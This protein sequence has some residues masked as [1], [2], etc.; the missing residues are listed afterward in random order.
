MGHFRPR[1]GSSR[2][3][4]VRYAPKA[5]DNHISAACRYGPGAVS[6]HAQKEAGPETTDL[7]HAAKF[8]TPQPRRCI[9]GN[10]GGRAGALVSFVDMGRRRAIQYEGHR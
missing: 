4:H 1:R 2:S 6:S 3:R 7:H 8:R 10:F 9:V 5:T